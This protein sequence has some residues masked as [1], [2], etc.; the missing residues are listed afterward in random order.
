MKNNLN[1]QPTTFNKRIQVYTCSSP[2]CRRL[3]SEHNNRILEKQSSG[4]GK[5]MVWFCSEEPCGLIQT[6]SFSASL[7]G[8]LPILGLSES[9]GRQ[10]HSAALLSDLRKSIWSLG[11][12]DHENVHLST[13]SASAFV[14][15]PLTRPRSAPSVFPG[16]I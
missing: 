13:D 1:F 2:T 6:L 15:V 8:Q 10:L 14:A 4:V 7:G 9:L 5:G 11:S 3:C 16:T 12:S